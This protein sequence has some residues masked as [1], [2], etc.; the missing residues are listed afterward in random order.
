MLILIGVGPQNAAL[1]VIVPNEMRGQVTAL[2]LFLFT[3]IGFGIA[4]TVVALLTDYVF[5]DEMK[6]RY[7]IATMHAVLAPLAAF[8]F[9]R[10]LERVWPGSCARPFLAE[11][12]PRHRCRRSPQVRSPAGS[13]C[14]TASTLR[15]GWRS[16]CAIARSRG[17]CQ[18][19]CAA[20]STASA[21]TSSIRRACR[22]SRS[23]AKAISACSASRT[24][25]STTA[26]ATCA[27]SATRRRPRRASRC[28]APTATRTPTIAR[29]AGLSRG[30]A[31]TGV[32]FHHGK[33]LV[34]KEDSPPVVVDAD[35]L[36]TLDDYY[37]FGG[38]LRS[39][40]FTAHPK[41]DSETGEL[42]AFGYEARGEATDDIAI[43]SFD[44]RGQLTWEAWI[45]APYVGLHTRLRRHAEPR[46]VSRD[47][48]W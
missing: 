1:Q 32:V 8:V 22:T 30:T 24:V 40:T 34:L 45:K 9:W 48:R 17:A 11:L 37:T 15:S 3:M 28:S 38:Q 35:S 46:R 26:A 14:G 39:L 31:N 4:P 25:T 10:G 29:V 13:R 43:M 6:L 2:F 18:P 21:R 16:T 23:T 47:L 7:S 19:T 44:T 5:R 12:I 36:E 20:A 33:L 42:V 41:I 27:R